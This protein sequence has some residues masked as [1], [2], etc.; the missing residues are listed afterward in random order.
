MFEVILCCRRCN[1][2]CSTPFT[3][4]SGR[5][6]RRRSNSIVRADWLWLLLV[7]CC[8]YH[9]A[10]VFQLLLWTDVSLL[11]MEWKARLFFPVHCQCEPIWT[12][13]C[14]YTRTREVSKN[15]NQIS[16]NV[17]IGWCCSQSSLYS[18]VWYWLV[19]PAARSR[20]GSSRRVACQHSQR[21][22][23][24]GMWCCHRMRAH[25]FGTRAK[26]PATKRTELL[27]DVM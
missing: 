23:R 17:V 18:F 8:R 11:T 16:K 15:I 3:A 9:G 24:R 12:S 14:A 10:C 20:C 21:T 25:P 2:D 4:C 26:F 13:T 19:I 27:H 22:T 7:L 1:A 6:S 5:W